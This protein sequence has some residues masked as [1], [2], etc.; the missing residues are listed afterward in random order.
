MC[1]TR[2]GTFTI[3]SVVR[4]LMHKIFDNNLL[5]WLSSYHSFSAVCFI[6]IPF[7]YNHL[8]IQTIWNYTHTRIQHTFFIVLSLLFKI[9]I[10]ERFYLY[11][12][13]ELYATY[14]YRTQLYTSAKKKR[15][16]VAKFPENFLCW[17]GLKT[18]QT[19]WKNLLLRTRLEQLWKTVDDEIVKDMLKRK[20]KLL[21]MLCASLW[22]VIL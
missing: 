1:I 3:S 20:R 16:R 17:L 4:T 6:I 2:L 7:K 5:C 19:K 9:V 21:L 22:S 8:V 18:M 12:Q 10:L 15:W 13:V 11:M 14:L